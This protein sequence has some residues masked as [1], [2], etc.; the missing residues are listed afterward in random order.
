[1]G[2]LALGESGEEWD[3]DCWREA[4]KAGLRGERIVGGFTGETGDGILFCSRTL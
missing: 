4:L 3:W 2:D 1:M